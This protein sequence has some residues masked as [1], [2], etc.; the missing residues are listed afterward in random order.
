MVD[1]DFSVEVRVV[2]TSASFGGGFGA[3]DV[4]PRGWDKYLQSKTQL[5]ASSQI[6]GTDLK[7]G[8]I[9]PTDLCEGEVHGW[10]SVPPICGRERLR[11][12]KS[13]PPICGWWKT[14][15]K[16]AVIGP[17][18]YWRQRILF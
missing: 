9:G 5:A 2:P 10:K 11:G 8:G 18:D 1:V 3:L 13:V 6:G 14:F 7:L 15:A 16:S 12:F 17:T 4:L